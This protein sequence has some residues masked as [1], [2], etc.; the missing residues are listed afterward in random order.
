MTRK[1]RTSSIDLV[2][3]CCYI[4]LVLAALLL[5]ITKI[6]GFFNVNV[7][8]TVMSVLSL[9]QEIAMLVGIAFG[10]YAFA[11]SKGKTWVIIYWVALIIY[12]A[13]AILGL[14]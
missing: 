5:A 10:A 13:A 9:I 8:G 2:H 14:F 12:I 1:Q 6:F 4:A 11:R 3:V 7:G